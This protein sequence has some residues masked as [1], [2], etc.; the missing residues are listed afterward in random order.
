MKNI[1]IWSLALALLVS[2][3]GCEKGGDETAN[4]GGVPKAPFKPEASVAE[5]QDLI[6]N[7]WQL[8][9]YA[10]QTVNF[11][12]YID[13]K[14]DNT[15][16]LYERTYGYE[17]DYRTGT[18]SL[19][20]NVLTGVYSSD[21]PWNNAYTIKIAKTNPLR[22]RLI[23]ANG[24]YAEYKQVD[25]VPSNVESTVPEWDG[26]YRAIP[27]ASA[28]V[29]GY[30]EITHPGQLATLLAE[31]DAEAFVAAGKKVRLMKDLYFN[32]IPFVPVSDVEHFRDFVLDG[33]GHALYDITV[34]HSVDD[35]GNVVNE[36]KVLALFP[37]AVDVTISDL[38]ISNI[39]V[40]AG[41][42]EEAYAGGLIGVSYGN[43]ELSNVVVKKSTIKGTNKVGGLVGFVAQDSITATE[44]GVVGST[45]ETNDVADESG[46]AGGLIGF[47]SCTEETPVVSVSTLDKC[48]VKNTTLNVINSRGDKTRANAEFIGGVGG[49][50]DDVLYINEAVIEKNTVNETNA[51]SYTAL[52][53]KYVGGSRGLFTVVIDRDAM[54]NGHISE[55][56]PTANANGVVEIVTPSHFAAL[57]T[58]GAK[59]LKVVLV[60][61]MNF[62]TRNEANE[63]VNSVLTPYFDASN[64]YAF[65]NLTIDGSD[66][67]ISN[68]TVENEEAPYLALFPD[69]VNLS[70]KNLK[71]SGIY[72]DAGEGAEA[73]AGALIARSY[74]NT[75]L[76]DVDVESC[77]IKGTNKVGGLVGLV[78]EDSIILKECEVTNST[79]ETHEMTNES[80]LAGGLI[81][82]LACTEQV[83]VAAESI[84]EEC[85]VSNNTFTVINST[86]DVRRAN[87][88]LIG[89]IGGNDG[90]IISFVGDI[91]V[92][93]N[94]WTNKNATAGKSDFYIGGNR[95]LFTVADDG[96]AMW[97][98]L[99]SE[100]LP[101]PNSKGVVEIATPSQFAA[102]VQNG[103]EEG[104]KVTLTNSLNFSQKDGEGNSV[105]GTLTPVV[106]FEKF[107]N[108]TIDGANK[109]VSNFS[110]ATNG[111]VAALFPE[112]AGATIKNLT[113]SKASIDAGVGENAYAGAL[114]GTSY[115]DVVLNNVVVKGST[116]KGT[117]KV[118]GLVGFVAQNSIS[119]TKSGIDVWVDELF[120]NNKVK[121]LIQ[122]H[123]MPDESGLA[124]GLIGYIACTEESELATESTISNCFVRGTK[125]D[126]VNSRNSVERSNNT[127]IGGIGGNDGDI[128]YIT[129]PEIGNDVEFK[130]TVSGYKPYPTYTD[131]K[132]KEYCY[133][134]GIRGLFTV[135]Y[136]G[137]AK[138]NGVV[139]A[140][141]PAANTNGVVEILTPSQFAALVSMGSDAGLKVAIKNNLDFSQRDSEGK[142]VN[143]TLAP[144]VG[145]EKFRAIEVDGGSKTIANF[146]I[147]TDGSVA[148]LFPEVAGATVKNLTISKAS[149]DAGRG[150]NAYAGTL[151]G[152][153][154]GDIVLTN[155]DVKESTVKGT[156]KIGALVGFVAQ[157]SITAKNC[158]VDNA[159]VETYNVDDESGLAGG[160]IG[161][162]G[163][164]GDGHIAKSTI[165][166]CTVKNSTLTLN[167]SRDSADRANSEFIGAIGGDADDELE[168]KKST[169]DKNKLTQTGV[170]NY[171][172]YHNLIGGKRG[173]FKVTVDGKSID[174]V[175]ETPGADDNTGAGSEE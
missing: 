45:I 165:E 167:N 129:K 71:L 10:G 31:T 46:L 36:N 4:N 116:I 172:A 63:A 120:A 118:G 92:E 54:W 155:V 168:I 147:V 160:F 140:A 81:G 44:C 136:E 68:L 75:R 115:G 78:A 90:D 23:E 114:I 7:K 24:Q 96:V 15:Y 94:T 97:N 145:Y 62:G 152:K 159:T 72:V 57:L 9:E 28:S 156:N 169:V 163:C 20:D 39:N 107:R 109:V 42:G 70:V 132:N 133:V 61:G 26:V 13:Y 101:T 99:V 6:A 131:E 98:G 40:D 12:V 157:N 105:N 135:V 162:I 56:L 3:A 74:G 89:A 33:N 50:D 158:D 174:I 166:S 76:E 53:D 55:A 102:L 30:I 19:E 41:N 95:G 150:D 123:N 84:I 79:I 83:P 117:N 153:S 82:Y 173:E 47:I 51:G 22:L 67:A 65:S 14:E 142:E 100:T 52:Y 11:D 48:F 32:N 104:L 8:V 146:S 34:A 66:N 73:Y 87:G 128:L 113:I 175:E 5:L 38:V 29:D 60:N 86:N 151:I 130:E 164:Q 112:V 121:S 16:E 37:Q 126:V 127:F 27:S 91:T 103:A 119:V 49:N 138:W 59:D 149:I 125:F 1:K 17:Y 80:G 58:K 134:G 106:N 21:E 88:D 35:E 144:V 139:S 110:I 25:K 141:L 108:I 171:K 111:S 2:L 154:Y 143:G 85:E 18:Y 77:T 64:V 93:D 148:A 137:T 161:Y 43:L 69:A 122:T 170:T 124:G